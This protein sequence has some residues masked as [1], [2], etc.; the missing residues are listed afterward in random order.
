MSIKSCYQTLDRLSKVK[1]TEDYNV[2]H[3]L[4]KKERREG[5]F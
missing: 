2:K 3:D 4:K 1:L 5:L